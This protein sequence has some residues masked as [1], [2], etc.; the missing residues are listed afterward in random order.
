MNS[1]KTIIICQIPLPYS[2]IASWSNMYNYLLEETTH[3]FDYI[4][5]PK[6]EVKA[7]NVIYEY[8][9]EITVKDKIK[10]KLVD[11][12]SRF[13][14]Y[15]E[16]LDRIINLNLETKFILHIIDNSGIVVPLDTHLKNANI[17]ENFY[18][19]YY[20]QG[21]APL[22][23]KK[24]ADPFLYAIDELFFL[25]ALS[26]NEY[27]NFYDDCTFRAKIVHN[28]T[29]SKLFKRVSSE[30]KEKLREAQGIK[31]DEFVFM[32]CSQD[33]PK[34]GLHLIL[35]AYKR[36]YKNHKGKIKLL[37]IGINRTIDQEGVEVV[38]R[39]PNKELAKYYQM[40]DVYL[41]PSLWK[42]GFG[43]VLAEAL[44]CGTY[45]IA[46]KQGGIPEVIGDGKYGVLI[47]NPNMINE[48]VD[49]MEKAIHVIR[50]NKGINPY[51]DVISERIY[52]VDDW[53]SKI[54][55]YIN[56]VKLYL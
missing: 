22:F 50:N 38:G 56:E 19:Q 40:S 39:V 1:I 4:I 53:A 54:N 42:E 28:A 27:K 18:I 5:C 11:D 31:Q 15:M 55:K 46:S 52:D 24:K 7:K 33:R 23:P 37:I 34:K 51:L 20:Y 32:W 48:W 30:E 49:E 47:E 12:T 25:T 29:N 14:N 17:R 36:V 6:G 26:Y 9:R 44:K 3:S 2:K 35:D 43:I 13:N 45:C 16:A 10:N 8:V 41:F 21:F